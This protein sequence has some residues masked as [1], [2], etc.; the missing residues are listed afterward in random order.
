MPKKIV[1]IGPSHHDFIEGVFGFSTPWET[2]LGITKT[3]NPG[4]PTIENDCEHSLEVELPFLQTVLN[5]FEFTPIT[6]GE[7]HPEELSVLLEEVLEEGVLVV[8]SDLS[9]YNEYTFATKKDFETIK[10]IVSLD[11]KRFMNTGDACGKIGIAALMIMAIK[12]QWKAYLIKYK[13]SGDTTNNKESVVGYCS[14]AFFD[15][16]K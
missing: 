10:S 5:E 7:I 9:H 1:L 4:L 14:I 6:Y 8:S 16:K 15:E 13:N 12:H 2:P 3:S 11:Y